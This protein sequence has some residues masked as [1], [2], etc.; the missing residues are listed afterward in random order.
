MIK[1]CKTKLLADLPAKK[2]T[3]GGS[4]ER[5]AQA[6][7][8][9]IEEEDGGKAIALTGSWGSG[10]S[11]VVELLRSKLDSQD[12]S[13]TTK[14]GV[15]V[16]DAWAHRGDP[17]RRSFLERLVEY[18]VKREW[19]KSENWEDDLETLA[20]RRETVETISEPVLTKYGKIVGFF[21]FFLPF[22]IALIGKYGLASLGWVGLVLYM[23][24]LLIAVVFWL[25]CSTDEE[26]S[27]ARVFFS[28]MVEKTRAKAVRT[29]DPT[30]LEFR[31][32]FNSI[33]DDA[34]SNQN[35]KLLVVIDNLDRIDPD[36]T[37]AIWATMRAFFDV[38]RE[39]THPWMSRFWLLVPFDPYSLKTLLEPEINRPIEGL[40]DAFR[41]KTFQTT[42][43]VSP[44]VRTDWKEFFKNRLQEAFPEHKWE[45]ELHTV[46]RLFSWEGLPANRPPT[47]RDIK[48]FINKVGALH[49]QW[50]D[51]IPLPIQA[52]YVLYQDRIENQEIDISDDNSIDLRIRRL[53]DEPEWQKYLAALH[54]NVSPEIAIQ[55]LLER[56]VT[57]AFREGNT[58]ELKQRQSI[59]GF[60]EVCEL[61]I[62]RN[63]MDWVRDQP[64]M[65]AGAALSLGGLEQIEG[66]EWKQLWRS[67]RMAASDVKSWTDLDE[68]MGKGIVTIVER[69]TE[70]DRSALSESLVRSLS[71][72]VP[73]P[74]VEDAILDREIAQQWVKGTLPFVR[75][76]HDIGQGELLERDFRVI[77]TARSY[78]EVMTVLSVD[79]DSEN[80]AT[81]YKPEKQGEDIVTGLGYICSE[82]ELKESYSDAIELMLKFDD[83]K[84]WPWDQLAAA[85][86][87]LLEANNLLS[88]NQVVGCGNTIL[89]LVENRGVPDG[90]LRKLAAEGHI[91]HYLQQAH[92]GKDNKAVALCLFLIFDFVPTGNISQVIGNSP[93]G[94]NVY[95]TILGKPKDHKPIVEIFT[96]L[97]LRFGRVQNLIEKPKTAPNTKEIVSAV[98]EIIGL[99]EDVHEHI[100]PTMFIEN[101][102]DMLETLPEDVLG[103]LTIQLVEEADLFS[104]IT[105]RGFSQE[106]SGLYLQTLKATESRERGSYVVH[107][108]DGLRELQKDEW[109]NELDQEGK[110]LDLLIYLVEKEESL[111]LELSFKDALYEHAKKMIED[112]VNAP[113]LEE[114]W[115]KLPEALS[116]G[117]KETFFRGLRDELI[118]KAEGN[119]EPVLRIYGAILLESGVLEERA[120]EVVR[121]LFREILAREAPGEL[122]WMHK[123]LNQAPQIIDRCKPAS[124]E[125]FMERVIQSLR[126]EDLSEDVVDSVQEIARAIGI[127]P[128]EVTAEE[129]ES[130][131]D[132]NVESS[133]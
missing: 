101:Y 131:D 95:N 2:D 18:L 27:I 117:Y 5:V 16:F 133:K 56:T 17:L 41:D 25:W 64:S 91:M 47:P 37:R 104:V 73:K 118:N 35:R 106:F 12:G 1:S 109:A 53:I 44:P 30:S 105:A 132:S 31:N 102:N 123:V 45:E 38:D 57:G 8:N 59:P 71:D 121:T 93:A 61:I 48:L 107:I 99:R 9:L 114:L 130:E 67:L 77:G 122:A 55:V 34:F 96:D 70:A 128:E 6:I 90:S 52:L 40:A 36:E 97:I 88:T 92:A 29:P 22:G 103:N 126:K 75:K 120:D 24:P 110:P 46:Y 78:I 7:V 43:R 86:T 84:K 108:R 79:E 39:E 23:L 50:G 66:P 89:N 98:V 113:K 49:R 115:P 87:P 116:P 94:I 119:I 81:F 125:E 15:F 4:H 58:E 54:F 83:S 72:S 85:I 80:L 63:Y 26:D 21:A 68:R 11:T 3:F 62:E 82:G 19:I 129:A 111:G 69:C 42:F 100:T 14:Y 28:K 10:K 13:R 51:D 65:I 76:L 74:E 127:D 112:E 20:Q 33:L 124:K 32:L 60:L